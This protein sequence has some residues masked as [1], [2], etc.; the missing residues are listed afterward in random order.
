MQHES[1]TINPGRWQDGGG[2]GYGIVQWDPSTKYLDWATD[3]GYADDSLIGQVEFLNLSMQPGY[4]EWLYNKKY[5]H[6]YMTY[7]EFISSNASI[8]Y[9]TQVFLH[10]YERAGVLHINERIKYANDWANYFGE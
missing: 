2:P 8:D 5:P 3:N 10:C 9:L 1:Y 6:F 4:R 7:T